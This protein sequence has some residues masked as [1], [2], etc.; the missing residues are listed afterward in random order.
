[1]PARTD[2]GAENSPFFESKKEKE[3]SCLKG[4]TAKTGRL[5]Q[6]QSRGMYISL[7]L[8]CFESAGSGLKCIDR[9]EKVQRLSSQEGH[10]VPEGLRGIIVPERAAR[11]MIARIQYP[12][13]RTGQGEQQSGK[14][15]VAFFPPFFSHLQLKAL[16]LHPAAGRAGRKKRYISF[17]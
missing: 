1:V 11:E 6:S 9:I 17:P 16:S 5:S 8:R 13:F 15:C 12:G 7:E 4:L 14:V 2:Y 3:G 10:T